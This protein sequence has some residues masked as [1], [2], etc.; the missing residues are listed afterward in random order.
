MRTLPLLL[1][2]LSLL[3]ALSF[4]PGASRTASA[5]P[6]STLNRPSDPVVLTG[7]GLPSFIGRAPNDI[8]ERETARGIRR[9]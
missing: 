5:M 7:A 8:V 6:S 9:G 3:L 1:A 2:A 4:A